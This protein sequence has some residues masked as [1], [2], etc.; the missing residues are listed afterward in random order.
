LLLKET[1][2]EWMEDGASGIAASLAY[3]TI[4]SLSPLLIIIALFLGL[5]LDEA[6]IETSFTDA[7]RGTV[8]DS[9]AEIVRSLVAAPRSGDGSDTLGSIV[10]LAVV[11]WGASG[12][13]AQL[14]SALNKIWEVKAAPG[15]SPFVFFKNKLF[16]FTIVIL[17]GL[18]LLTIM[19]T[20][21]VISNMLG[22]ANN[23]ALSIPIRIGQFIVTMLMSTVLIA[24]V[25]KILPDV[26]IRWRDLWVG[27]A[28]T[29]FLFFVGQLIVGLYL[30]RSNVGSVFGAASSLTAILVWIYY[31]AQ[32]LL[33]GAEF[34]EVW[35]RHYGTAIR[36]DH[37]A[38]WTN[39]AHARREAMRANV[40][41]E[42]TDT[43]V[44]KEALMAEYRARRNERV[45]KVF[46]TVKDKLDGDDDDNAKPVN[47]ANPV[48]DAKSVNHN[49]DVSSDGQAG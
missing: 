20:N 30:S 14:Q 46:T 26:I 25:F 5:I 19:F 38:T 33:F 42:E 1:V 8:G 11:V 17:V 3:Y 43:E 39:E 7:L 36:P 24:A 41:F 23:L 2:R 9:G 22:D 13:F 6:T 40:D 32:I 27:S 4:F 29:A 15:R 28:F 31:S 44:F 35:A 18:V 49:N 10:W 34:T 37:D 16:S 47:N 48:N 12:L 45:K 21:S